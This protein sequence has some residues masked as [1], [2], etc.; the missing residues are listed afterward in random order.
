ARPIPIPCASCS[1][2][3]RKTAS[4]PSCAIT[5]C[6]PPAAKACSKVRCSAAAA[7]KCGFRQPADC[8]GTGPGTRW[9]NLGCRGRGRRQKPG[10]GQPAAEQGRVGGHRPAQLQTG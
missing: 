5:P 6:A 7:L 8:P 3:C 2:N 4:A 10:T 1:N 9:K